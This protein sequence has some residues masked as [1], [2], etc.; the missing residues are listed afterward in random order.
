MTNE[1]V[2]DETGEITP[3]DVET[4]TDSNTLDEDLKERVRRLEESLASKDNELASLKGALANAVDKYR[5]AVLATDPGVPAELLKGETVE[6]IDDSLEQARRIVLQVRQ[7]LDNDAAV[8][9]GLSANLNSAIR[10]QNVTNNAG[11]PEST[12]SGGVIA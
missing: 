12:A 2:Q 7:Q 3:Y 6:D 5:T 4:E 8:G 10:K 1:I 9:T 11:T